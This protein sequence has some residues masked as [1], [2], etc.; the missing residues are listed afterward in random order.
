MWRVYGRTFV[1]LARA[2]SVRQYKG[3]IEVAM[4]RSWVMP[5]TQTQWPRTHTYVFDMGTE[6][7]AKAEFKAVAVLLAEYGDNR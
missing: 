1:N 3:T 7:L 4:P 5:D 2:N 6:E